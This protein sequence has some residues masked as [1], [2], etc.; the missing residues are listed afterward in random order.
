MKST[1]K[2]FHHDIKP[3]KIKTLMKLLIS[4]IIFLKKTCIVYVI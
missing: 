2:R 4:N 3:F 1:S